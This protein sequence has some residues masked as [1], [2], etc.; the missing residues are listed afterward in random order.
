MFLHPKLTSVPYSSS[1]HT[2]NAHLRL[3]E[4]CA[5]KKSRNM[6]CKLPVSGDPELDDP[7][8]DDPTDP[9]LDNPALDDPPEAV[10]VDPLAPEL[11]VS[12]LVCPNKPLAKFRPRLT[13]L[14][15]VSVQRFPVQYE[16]IGISS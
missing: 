4:G 14:T 2:C 15:A 9:P 1:W 8:L 13:T 16:G 12:E 7:A 5:T 6:T 11:D 10:L 3:G